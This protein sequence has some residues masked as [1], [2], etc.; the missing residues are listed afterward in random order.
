MAKRFRIGFLFNHEA[1]HQVAHS[2]PTAFTL[3]THYAERVDVSLY[4]SSPPQ[5]TELR[6]IASYYPDHRCEFVQID[7]PMAYKALDAIFGKLAPFRKVAMLRA[8][9]ERFAGLNALV[10]TE[11]TSIML[12]TRFG[13]KNVKLIYARHGAGDRALS[14]NVDNAKFDLL[15]LPGEKFQ[16]RLAAAGYLEDRPHVIVGYPK[17]DLY[18]GKTGLVSREAR[19]VFNNGRKTVLYNP[20]F[21]PKLSSWYEFSEAVLEYFYRSDQYNL[22]FAPH[23]MLYKRLAHV[24]L[25]ERTFRLRKAPPQRYS[26]CPHMLIDTG[27]PACTDMTYTNAADIYL[28]DISSQVYEFIY[29]PRP[30]VFLNAHDADW[31]DNPNYDFW[32]MGEVIDRPEQLGEALARA[33]SLHRE[34]FEPIQKQAFSYTFDIEETRPS[35]RAARAIVDYLERPEGA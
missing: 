14:F 33:E 2:A 26:D 23:M 34:R 29:T 17:F 16:D 28:G 1:T 19:P 35:L 4:A 32:R 18:G 10:L 30:C 7:C 12:K 13:L 22:I 6:R 27:G 5:M 8:N 9:A 24:S 25:E 3:S 15:L 21:D 11:K 31:R 20:H